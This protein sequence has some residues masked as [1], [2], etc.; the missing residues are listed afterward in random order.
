MR[1]LIGIISRVEAPGDT[2]RLVV[3]DVYR[4]TI[5]KAGGIPI[6][7]LPPQDIDYGKTKNS[8]VNR[9]NKKEEEM[10]LRQLR[11]CDGILMPGGFKILNFDSFILDYAIRE[12]IPILGICLG[13]QVM[14]NYNK[15]IHC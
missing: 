9:F 1:P 5:I 3:N 15:K 11:L 12:D 6:L 10:I 8:E 7:I 2:E 13:M 14:A 4:R